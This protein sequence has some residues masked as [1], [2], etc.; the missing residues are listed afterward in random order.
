MKAEHYT[1]A[2]HWLLWLWYSDEEDY[3]PEES[4]QVK[5]WAAEVEQE[6]GPG[7]WSYD[8]DEQ[9]QIAT[10][11]VTGLRANCYEIQWAHLINWEGK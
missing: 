5:A 8:P 1:V 2:E 11:D 9:P 3:T 7:H 4:A 10:D 6:H